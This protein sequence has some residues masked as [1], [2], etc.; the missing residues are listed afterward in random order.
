MALS[1]EETRQLLN[2]LIF[3]DSSAQDWVQDVWGLSP[4]LGETAARLVDAFEAVADCTS[5]EQLENLVQGLYKAQ[6]EDNL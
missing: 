4:T 1:S 2:R 5:P 3:D 6:L